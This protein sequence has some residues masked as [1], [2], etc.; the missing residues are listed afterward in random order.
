MATS[1][2]LGGNRTPESTGGKDIDSLGP[3]DNSDSG[4][5]AMGAYGEDSDSDSVGT[6]NR[7]SVEGP[8]LEHTDGDILPDHLESADGN[9]IENSDMDGEGARFSDE[10]AHTDSIESLAADDDSD[11]SDSEGSIE[12]LSNA[13]SDRAA[14]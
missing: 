12:S 7:A 1:S 5:D 8:G 3:S 11:E 10:R 13:D 14:Y 4:S 9:E 2:I 6:G